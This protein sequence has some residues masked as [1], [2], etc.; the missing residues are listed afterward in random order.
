MLKCPVHKFQKRNRECA[1]HLRS[2]HSRCR[3]WFGIQV[4]FGSVALPKSA[5]EWLKLTPYS[6]VF[7]PD[8]WVFSAN[9]D[10]SGAFSTLARFGRRFAAVPE[11]Q[12]TRPINTYGYSG[13]TRF[14]LTCNASK[15]WL[16]AS[17]CPL[18]AGR[19]RGPPV[20]HGNKDLP[21][22]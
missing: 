17:F 12:S 22:C 10:C 4:H 6:M 9:W 20:A 11:S 13:F 5:G 1:I 16:W 21:S 18:I 3:Q 19:Y 15:Q 8:A 7:T 14:T 2:T